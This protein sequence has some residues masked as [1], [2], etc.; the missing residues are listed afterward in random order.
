MGT[1]RLRLISPTRLEQIDEIVS[2]VGRDASGSFGILANAFRRITALS[3][4]VATLRKRTDQL[5]TWLF[6][7][8]FFI[9]WRMSSGLQPPALFAAR[10]WKKSLR[11]WIGI[12][13]MEE[14]NIREIK[15]SLHHLDEEILRRLSTIGR[16]VGVS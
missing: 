13:R 5:N 10:R 2:F 7:G 4:G 16:R 1:S 6:P 15:Q 11:R 3:F 12:V 14:E 8:G 9:S